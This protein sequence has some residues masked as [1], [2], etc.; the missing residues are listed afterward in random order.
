MEAERTER[1]NKEEELIKKIEA[2]NLEISNMIKTEQ[3]EREKS[4]E[5]LLRLLESACTKLNKSIDL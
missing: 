2:M 3:A 1:D 5:A 4:Q